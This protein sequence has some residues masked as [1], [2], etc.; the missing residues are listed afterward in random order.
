MPTH[1]CRLRRVLTTDQNINLQ[2]DALGKAGCEKIFQDK[3]SGAKAM[4]PGLQAAL[5]FI[6]AGDTLI[7]WRLDRLGR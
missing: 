3:V 7:V 6:K 4:R 5:K 2:L 1:V